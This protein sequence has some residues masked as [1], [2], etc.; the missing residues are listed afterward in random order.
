MKASWNGRHFGLRCAAGSP[1]L[2]IASRCRAARATASFIARNASRA[3]G[4]ERSSSTPAA[5]RSRAL[6]RRGDQAASPSLAAARLRCR[7]SRPPGSRSRPHRGAAG[8]R[9]RRRRASAPLAARAASVFHFELDAR[10]RLVRLDALDLGARKEIGEG[11]ADDAV[12]VGCPAGRGVA[13]DGVFGDAA[14]VEVGER[15]V[16][17]ARAEAGHVAAREEAGGAARLQAEP[18]KRRSRRRS[19]AGSP[20]GG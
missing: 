15:R 2:R 6:S 14:I 1:P 4:S 11:G 20:C 10:D 7:R 12:L 5:M 19:G 18:G 13:A 3:C 9:A 17:I 8:R 16:G